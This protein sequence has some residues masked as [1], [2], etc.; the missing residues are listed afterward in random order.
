MKHILEIKNVC[1][2]FQLGKTKMFGEQ[3]LLKA[4]ND[5]SFK[6]YEGE[7]LGIIGESGCGKSTLGRCIVNLYNTTYGQIFYNQPEGEIN[8][9]QSSER[10]RQYHRRNIQI[11]FQDP[12]ASLNPRINIFETIAEPL[13]VNGFRK[14]EINQR[15]TEIIEEV[16]LRREHLRRFPH[17]FSGGQRQR[18]GI[19]RALVVEPKI[20]ICDEAVSALD[21]SVQ[22]QIINLLKKL[23]EKNKFTYIFISHDM[24]VINHICDRIA[25]MYAGKIVEIGKKKDVL[26]YPKHPYTEALIGAIPKLTNRKNKIKR[27]S[28]VGEPPDLTSNMWGCYLFDRCKYRS[29]ECKEMSNELMDIENSDHKSSCI[30]RNEVELTGL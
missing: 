10:V 6:L 28:L 17:S 15:V 3:I 2:F 8:L 5:V 12:F 19:A 21:V 22:A 9:T 16:G 29:A 18:I 27:K 7:T 23:Q 14:E 4:V 1:K 25:V 11:I 24:S 20:V 30:K 26:K 13:I